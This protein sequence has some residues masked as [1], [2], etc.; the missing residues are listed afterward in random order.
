MRI[1]F[2]MKMKMH[3]SFEQ[4][5]ERLC[6]DLVIPGVVLVGGDKSGMSQLVLELFH[7]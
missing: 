5:T 7:L 1:E 3:Q 4:K 2:G 6:Q